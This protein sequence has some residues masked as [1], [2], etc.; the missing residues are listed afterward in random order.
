MLVKLAC[1][2]GNQ[3]MMMQTSD[4]A[5]LWYHAAPGTAVSLLSNLTN[6]QS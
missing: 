6:K 4:S 1:H 3:I 2:M 5:D